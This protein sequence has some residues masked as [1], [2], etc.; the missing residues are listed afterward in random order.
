MK[1]EKAP[2]TELEKAIVQIVSRARFPP[3]TAAKRFIGDRAAGRI[4]ELSDR[5]RG[6]LAFIA[7]RFR[8]QYRL[9]ADQWAWVREWM[10]PLDLLGG[11]G[12][13]PREDPPAEAKR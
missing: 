3:A 12:V 13:V 4:R 7:H 5:G 2:L 9:E 10:R 1:L 11:P 8:R 6:S